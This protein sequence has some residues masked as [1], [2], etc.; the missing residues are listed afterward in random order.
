[1]VNQGTLEV[2]AVSKSTA[3]GTAISVAGTTSAKAGTEVE[4]TAT[5]MAGG[6]GEDILI[7]TGTLHV[8]PAD[9][10]TGDAR[11]M[12]LLDTD[13]SSFGFAGNTNAESSAFAPTTST[14]ITGGDD[15]DQI[16]NSGDITVVASALNR[17]SSETVNIFGSSGA[18]GESGAFTAAQGISGDQGNDRIDNSG[19]LTLGANAELMLNGSSYTFGGSGDT[20]GVLAAI[21]VWKVSRGRRGRPYR[22]QWSV[23]YRCPGGTQFKRRIGSDFR[24]LIRERDFR[25]PNLCGGHHRR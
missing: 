8:G 25:W 11:W 17:S 21:T 1:M 24:R 23:G 19:N 7:N 5:G 2:L 3:S 15:N 4:T 6:A 18:A 13:A 12:S 9:G 16:V 14:G 20:G 10:A 22:Q